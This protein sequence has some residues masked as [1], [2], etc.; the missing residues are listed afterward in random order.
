MQRARLWS[1]GQLVVAL[2][3]TGGFLA[4]LLISPSPPPIDPSDRVRPPAEAASVIGFGRIRVVP[5][6]PFDERISVVQVRKVEVADPELRVSG[7]VVASLRPSN[8]RGGD[9]WQFDSPE[10]LSAYSD[11]RKAQEDIAFSEIQLEQTRQLASTRLE[12]QREVVQRLESLVAAGTDTLKDLFAERANLIQLEIAGRQEVHQAET[13]LRIA[14]REEAVQAR[15][16]QQ[17][18]LDVDLLA[19]VDSD[20]DI[21]M[22]DVPEARLNQVRIGQSCEARF[23]GAPRELFTGKVRSIAPVLSAERRA[24]RVLFTIDDPDDKLRPGMFAEIGLGTDR[25][26]A[27]MIPADAVLHVGRSDY[28]LAAE[29]DGVWRVAEVLVGE[30][31][32]ASVAVLD[33]LPEGA[34]IVGKGAVLFKPLVVRSLQVREEEAL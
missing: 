4:Y 1:A 19:S 15:V 10:V 11:W 7:R 12:A 27:L 23:Y 24:L 30:P 18:G 13:D 14:R 31:R 2:A 29:E 8:G 25:R 6:S 5:G 34:R 21:V 9:F 28:V 20:V 26:E 22:A 33:G 3:A 32:Y 16:L 17:A